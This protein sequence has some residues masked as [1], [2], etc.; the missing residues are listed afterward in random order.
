MCRWWSLLAKPWLP[1][2]D[3]TVLFPFFSGPIFFHLTG[4]GH[5]M[6]AL[7]EPHEG[8]TEVQPSWKPQLQLWLRW[9]QMLPT[10]SGHCGV[11]KGGSLLDLETEQRQP[12]PEEHVPQ[13]I[14]IILSS[15]T[16]ADLSVFFW[17]MVLNYVVLHFKLPLEVWEPVLCTT[18]FQHD[19]EWSL[20]LL[21][22]TGFLPVKW[23]Q[24][25]SPSQ[26]GSMRLTSLTLV[27][28]YLQST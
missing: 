13:H 23:E 19:L 6:D 17:L 18:D 15:D 24:P 22:P 28:A 7:S 14:I 2:S 10:P 20:Q 1:Y 3:R 4:K 21:C 25:P 27:S 5:A 26:A 12:K 11:L 8:A 9:R 16:L